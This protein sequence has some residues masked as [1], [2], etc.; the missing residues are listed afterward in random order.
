[1]TAPRPRPTA[2]A[3]RRPRI[4]AV[5]QLAVGVLLIGGSAACYLIG[6]RVDSWPAYVA[7]T[8]HTDIT[9]WSGPWIGAAVG[10]F[11]VGLPLIAA[12]AARLV[13][14]RYLTAGSRTSL[15]SPVGP[16]VGTP[17]PAAG[18]GHDLPTVPTPVVDRPAVPAEP[19]AG[20]PTEG[21]LGPTQAP[22]G[23]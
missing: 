23:T 10:L 15:S 11:V 4:V 21:D 16:T 1:M 14:M 20:P 18:W 13:R 17:W 22:P 2:A 9:R 12:G 5:V 6:Q 8:T 7:G 3:S 19:A